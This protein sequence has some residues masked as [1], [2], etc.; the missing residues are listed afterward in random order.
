MKKYETPELLL[1]Y[2]DVCDVI[3]ASSGSSSADDDE[4]IW[5]PYY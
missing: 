2:A 1:V 4:K 3:T 5:T